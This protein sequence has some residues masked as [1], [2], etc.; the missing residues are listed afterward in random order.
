M[1]DD[2]L[3]PLRPSLHRGCS[4]IRRSHRRR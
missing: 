4:P 1:I 3:P 2:G